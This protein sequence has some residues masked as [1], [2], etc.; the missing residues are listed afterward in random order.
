MQELPLRLP[1]HKDIE[2]RLPHVKSVCLILPAKVGF[3]HQ[4]EGKYS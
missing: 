3:Y 2:Y 4:T 1:L